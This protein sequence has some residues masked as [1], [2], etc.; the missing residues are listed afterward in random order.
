MDEEI[1]P[2][3]ELFIEDESDS[4]FSRTEPPSHV[5]QERDARYHGSLAV[6]TVSFLQIGQYPSILR[7]NV[8]ITY[9]YLKWPSALA[10]W[11]KR[12][13][14]DPDISAWLSMACICK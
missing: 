4:T 13:R 12:C 3:R 2:V 11:S 10:Q 1:A 8:F 14:Y 9:L 6:K 7:I 5:G